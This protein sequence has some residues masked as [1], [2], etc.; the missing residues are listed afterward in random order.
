MSANDF[1]SGGKPQ[2]QEQ[3]YYPPPGEYSPF[4]NNAS[5]P[6]RTP[7]PSPHNMRRPLSIAAQ[8]RL[9]GLFSE[10]SES[11]VLPED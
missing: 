2:G 7:K 8:Y 1:Y 3:Q 9:A 11:I 5:D 6:C 10:C 4:C